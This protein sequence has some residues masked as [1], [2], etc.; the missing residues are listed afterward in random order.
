MVYVKLNHSYTL[1]LPSSLLLPSFFPPSSL[2]L[3]SFLPPS[4]LLLSQ[5][6][7]S[8]NDVIEVS[9]LD[10][11]RHRH[12]AVIQDTLGQRFV[13]AEND[14][15]DLNIKV[16]SYPTNLAAMEVRLF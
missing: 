11:L 13:D 15:R 6:A 14:A 5:V 2:L 3:S 1:F 4:S 8:S 16:H 7:A 12:V 10:A 9:S